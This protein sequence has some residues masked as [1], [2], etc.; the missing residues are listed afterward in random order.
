MLRAVALFRRKQSNIDTVPQEV[1]DYYESERRE[2]SGMAW[3]LAI[4]T[5][6]MTLILA[7]GIFLG[8]RWAYRK[9]V[10][11]DD[12]PKVITSQLTDS[13]SG[14]NGTDAAD[15]DKNK[16]AEPGS[17]TTSSG[18]N[19]GTSS[20]PS[21]PATTP[22]TSTPAPSTSGQTSSTQTTTTPATPGQ[23]AGTPTT[24]ATTPQATPS[25]LT[26]TGPGSVTAAFIG[27]VIGGTLL[28]G[29]ITAARRKTNE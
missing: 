10:K 4:G 16:Q 7:A 9:I 6:V 12:K 3:L 17:G 19:S 25:S 11:N 14:N 15:T 27:A 28:H 24:T 26:N 13:Q 2:R 18:T 20:T 1:R 23:G 29:Y 5:L 21:A 22:A 8:G